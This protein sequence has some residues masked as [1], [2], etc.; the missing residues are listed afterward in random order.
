MLRFN[1]PGLGGCSRS[2][3]LIDLLWKK[4]M[5][6]VGKIEFEGWRVEIQK[7]GGCKNGSCDDHLNRF[8]NTKLQRMYAT[9]NSITDCRQQL[10]LPWTLRGDLDSDAPIAEV[11]GNKWASIC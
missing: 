7:R 3:V 1:F 10:V 9:F 2:S 6:K 8:Q 5:W 4:R 11:I